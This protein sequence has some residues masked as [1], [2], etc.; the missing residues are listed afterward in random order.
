MRP[1][2]GTN[3]P[4]DYMSLHRGL[5][6]SFWED[7]HTKGPMSH[8]RTKISGIRS[9]SRDLNMSFCEDKHTK[10][11]YVPL[12]E[13]LCEDKIAGIRSLWAHSYYSSLENNIVI[14]ETTDIIYLESLGRLHSE[15][16][17]I[18]TPYRELMSELH[19]LGSDSL[20]E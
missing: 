3:I 20:T 10:G 8:V 7:K 19:V 14:Y 16:G 5:N 1:I 2:A 6:A 11:L 17:Q 12:K 18:L 9:L 4:R 15:V 13:S